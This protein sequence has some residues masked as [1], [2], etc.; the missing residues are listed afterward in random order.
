[1]RA[2]VPATCGDSLLTPIVRAH[3]S[4]DSGSE[5]T[6]SAGTLVKV[7]ALSFAAG[8][9]CGFFFNRKLRQL[10]RSWERNL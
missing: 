4:M 1:V 7:G 6:V 8:V 3:Q 9:A 2:L 5:R 10:L